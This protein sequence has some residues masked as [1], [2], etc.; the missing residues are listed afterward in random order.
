[1]NILAL[2]LTALLFGGM[3]LYSFGFA[4]FVLRAL[5]EET[6]RPLIRRAFPHFYL[7]VLGTAS[8]AAVCAAFTDLLST[9]ILVVIALTTLYARQSLM[10]RINAATDAGHSKRFKLLHFFSVLITLAHIASA[11]WAIIRLGVAL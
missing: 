7:F 1:M 8:L 5:P 3:T 9:V 2:L 10:P 4:A 6:A 11:A